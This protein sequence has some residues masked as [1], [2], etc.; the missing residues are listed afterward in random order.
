M[1][2]TIYRLIQGYANNVGFTLEIILCLC[3]ITTNFFLS[4]FFDAI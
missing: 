1:Q 2:A 4:Q 3:K